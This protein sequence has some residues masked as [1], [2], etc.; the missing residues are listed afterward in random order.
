MNTH[1]IS[2]HCNKSTTVYTHVYTHAYTASSPTG[3]AL[4]Q[5]LRARGFYGV[6]VDPDVLE[7]DDGREIDVSLHEEIYSEVVSMR[8]YFGWMCSCGFFANIPLFV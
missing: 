2:A 6:T 3:S 7:S 8:L 5:E 4:E 1:S